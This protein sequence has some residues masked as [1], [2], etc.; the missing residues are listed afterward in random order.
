ML[1]VLRSYCCELVPPLT[2]THGRQV[3]PRLQAFPKMAE[4]K[5]AAL[6]LGAGRLAGAL[7]SL[8]VAAALVAAAEEGK[9]G[10]APLNP[11]QAGAVVAALQEG[12][13]LLPRLER[14]ELEEEDAATS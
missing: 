14:M 9:S 6:Q 10:G 5:E 4:A 2:G 13:A 3:M 1:P 11:L 12:D 7:S 8:R